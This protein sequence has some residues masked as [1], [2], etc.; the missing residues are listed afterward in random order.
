MGKKSG[1]DGGKLIVT[2]AMTGAVFVAKKVLGAA[3]SRTTGHEAPTDPRDRTVSLIEALG[4]AALAGIVGEVV[5]LL[6]A[7]ATSPAALPTAEADGAEA[8]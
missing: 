5:K 2:L 6:V 4:Y 3:W 8:G 7:R 1:D